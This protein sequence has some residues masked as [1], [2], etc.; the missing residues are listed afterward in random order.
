MIAGGRDYQ[1]LDSEEGLAIP[2]TM[3]TF[4]T[5]GEEQILCEALCYLVCI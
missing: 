5:V 1:V 2:I 3:E 4:Q